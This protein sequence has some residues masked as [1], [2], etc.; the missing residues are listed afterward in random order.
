MSEVVVFNHVTLDGVMQAPGRPDED[1]RGGFEHGGW[2]ASRMDAVVGAAAA[3]GMARG[4][5][6]LLGRRTYVLR[7][8]RRL[9]S[10]GGAIYNTGTLILTNSTIQNSS[11]GQSGGAIASTG[12]VTLTPSR[13]PG[14]P[15]FS[16]I[17]WRCAA[18]T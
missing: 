10:D 7:S 12:P 6:L 16:M 13:G 1:R 17:S 2:A 3:E 18:I 4:G 15:S 11:S 5:S 8:G 14:S 9:F